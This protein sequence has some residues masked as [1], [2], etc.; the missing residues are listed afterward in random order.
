MAALFELAR[1]ANVA[2]AE[3][4]KRRIKG[5]LLASAAL[6]GLLEQDPE[7]WFSGNSDD[8][9]GPDPAEIETLIEARNDARAAKDF[10]ESDRIRDELS[11]K[12]ILLEDGA[13]GTKW[14]R[15]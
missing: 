8:G 2:T 10:A 4:D 15:A 1:Q 13:G 9:D 6:I 14:R 3:D 11:A 5:T 12:G 7:D